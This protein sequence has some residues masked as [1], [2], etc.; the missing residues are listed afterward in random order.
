MRL[1]AENVARHELAG[2]ITL[3]RGDGL[4]ALA[5]EDRFDLVLCNPPYVN[6]RSMAALPPEYRAEPELA[7]AGGDDG[8]DFVRT[9]V[10]G[11][12]AHLKPEGALL[13]EIGH[14]RRHF[15]AAFPSLSPVWLSTSAGEDEVLWLTRADLETE[16]A[17][18]RSAKATRKTAQ[19]AT[20]NAPQNAPR[21][22]SR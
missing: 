20:R 1:A 10:A 2:R 17:P 12:A 21:K 6:A 15:E 7:L 19:R 8:M 3:R 4:A 14:E 18:V 16:T 5:A 11:V 9:L 13:L 22:A